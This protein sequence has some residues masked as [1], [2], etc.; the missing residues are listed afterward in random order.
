MSRA[1]E[2][3]NLVGIVI[4]VTQRSFYSYK[5]IDW[6]LIRLDIR[7][8]IFRQA[9]TKLPKGPEDPGSFDVCFCVL[10]SST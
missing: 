10:Y 4:T 3:K 8:V 7:G 9:D 5:K 1:K 2:N 6:L